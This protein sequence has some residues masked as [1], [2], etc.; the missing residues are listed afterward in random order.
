MSS[1]NAFLELFS[2]ASATPR[3]EFVAALQKN[4]VAAAKAPSVR[5]RLSAKQKILL[6]IGVVVVILAVLA[7]VFLPKRDMS[8][9]SQSSVIETVVTQSQQNLNSFTNEAAAETATTPTQ[10]GSS[11]Q[12]QPTT[13]QQT[14]P[15][16]QQPAAPVPLQ[17]FTAEF[18]NTPAE[19]AGPPAMPGGAPVFTT[20]TN[21]IAYSWGAGSPAGAVQ[22]DGFVARFSKS[23]S[24]PH[25]TY[26]VVY[27][28]DNGLRMFVNETAVFDKWSSAS[29]S[30]MAYFTTDPAVPVTEIIIEYYEADGSAS[31]SVEITKVP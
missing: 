13:Q 1:T 29:T 2:D 17:G 24:L 21:M 26:K 23:V 7:L 15:A 20:A 11:Q 19:S 16:T 8:D 9:P 14:V 22:T 10:Q 4:F 18:W 5:T 12:T 6:G 28:S 25:G 30:G 31:V 3:A 27:A